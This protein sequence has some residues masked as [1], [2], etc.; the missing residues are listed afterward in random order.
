L[1][2]VQTRKPDNGEL[3]AQ[4]EIEEIAKECLVLV[5]GE[6]RVD[7]VKDKT[8]FDQRIPSPE[9]KEGATAFKPTRWRSLS[10]RM[11]RNKKSPDL[12][13]GCDANRVAS[14][15]L[16]QTFLPMG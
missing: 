14:L 16:Y 8:Q 12:V 4:E 1:I 6:G 2:E 15:S 7:E 3:L 13:T 10:C 5:I 9:P 11:R